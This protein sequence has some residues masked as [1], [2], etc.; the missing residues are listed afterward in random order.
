MK[1]SYLC[2]SFKGLLNHTP[3]RSPR[4]ELPDKSSSEGSERGDAYAHG[5]YILINLDSNSYF[6]NSCINSYTLYF[7]N[8]I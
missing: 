2:A 5:L 8:A 6:A 3:S 4:D 1:G 7:L